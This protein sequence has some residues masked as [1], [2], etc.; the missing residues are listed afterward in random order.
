MKTVQLN[1]Y[2]IAGLILFIY[3]FTY[4]WLPET[5]IQDNKEFIRVTKELGSEKKEKKYWKTMYETLEEYV[6]NG[7]IQSSNQV[8]IGS[9]TSAHD[10]QLNPLP[11]FTEP[12]SDGNMIDKYF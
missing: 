8:T 9:K 4:F 2:E 1:V 10:S 3:V 11:Y 7:A 6:K 5:N 12:V